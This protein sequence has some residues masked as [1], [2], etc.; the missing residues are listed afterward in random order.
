MAKTPDPDEIVE[1]EWQLQLAAA[2]YVSGKVWGGNKVIKRHPI[3]FHFLK[4]HHP[5]MEYRGDGEGNKYRKRGTTDGIPDWLLWGPKRWH[6]FIELKV[7]ERK[8]QPN[9]QE[10]HR[11]AVDYGF[12]HAVCYTV[13]EFRDTL[14]KWGWECHNM[15]CIEP[16]YR[17][18][19]QLHR[20]AYKAFAPPS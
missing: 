7:A 5:A 20:L 16:V 15:A 3:P 11:W 8:L 19:A 9:Q 14:I 13:H 4:F 2:T 10:W 6:G 1:Y 18:K 17:T 12:P